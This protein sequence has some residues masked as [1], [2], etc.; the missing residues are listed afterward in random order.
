MK[1]LLIIIF[2]ANGESLSYEA[3][4]MV[5]GNTCVVA[6]QGSVMLLELTNPGIEATD[7]C[8]KLDPEAT[9]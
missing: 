9:S 2:T 7:I 4:H 8:Q 6:G 5:D 3:G 1:W